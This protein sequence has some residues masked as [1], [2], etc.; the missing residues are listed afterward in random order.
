MWISKLFGIKKPKEAPASNPTM[1]IAQLNARVQPIDRG[2][3][4]EDPLDEVLRSSGLGEVTGGGTQ[5]TDEP[6]GIEF[7]DVEIVVNDASKGTLGTII[8]TLEQLGAPK[9]SLLKVSTEQDAIRFGK[10]EGLA[11]F[12]NGTDLPDEVYAASDINNIVSRCNELMEGIGS[13]RGHWEG[14]K[15]TALYFYGSDFEAMKSAIAH[16]V[17]NDPLCALSRIVQ[18]A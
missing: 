8:D 6:D 15:E 9:G 10:L 1:V 16:F 13:F 12:L 7:C 2:D 11:L 17:E 5:L 3:Y 18:I 14:S 4:F